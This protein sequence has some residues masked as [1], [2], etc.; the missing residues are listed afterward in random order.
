MNIIFLVLIVNCL[1]MDVVLFNMV[2]VEM[3]RGMYVN[4]EW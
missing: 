1:R 2:N 3:I 4:G